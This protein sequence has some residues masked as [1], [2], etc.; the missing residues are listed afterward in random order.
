M[1]NDEPSQERPQRVLLVDDVPENI[2]VLAAALADDFDVFFAISGEEALDA[3]SRRE[4]DL[5]ILDIMMPEVDGYEVCRLLKLD[6]HLADIPV[7]FVTAKTDAEDEA[8]GFAVGGVDYITKPITPMI[9]R[10]RVHT[11]LQLKASR[12]RLRAL[13][14]QDAVTGLPDRAAFD[15][16]LARELLR[17]R[18][19]AEALTLLL[20]SLDG[21]EIFEALESRFGVEQALQRIARTLSDAAERPLDVCARYQ[22]EQFALCCPMTAADEAAE[23]GRALIERITGLGIRSAGGATAVRLTATVVGVTVDFAG[24]EDPA[25]VTVGRLFAACD[26]LLKQAERSGRRELWLRSWEDLAS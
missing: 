10:A 6:P 17:A 3:V 18:I 25:E 2:E 26:G 14:Q 16:L 8:K 24:V 7:I 12:D 15:A 22:R 23:L 1:S 11:H 19:E 21:F 9:V 4:I 5:I 13:A 20:V